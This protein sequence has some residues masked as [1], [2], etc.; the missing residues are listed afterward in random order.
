MVAMNALRVTVR[1][2]DNFIPVHIVEAVAS[3]SKIMMGGLRG[4]YESQFL[5]DCVSVC[6]YLLRFHLKHFAVISYLTEF[7]SA[8]RLSE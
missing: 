6:R 1:V 8:R 7:E 5:L 4:E 3:K 2:I